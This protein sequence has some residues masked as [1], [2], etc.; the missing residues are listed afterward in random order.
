MSPGWRSPTTRS[1]PST[2]LTASMRP[3]STAKSAR[4]SPSCAAYSPGMRLMSAAT[5]ESRSRSAASSVGEDLDAA[6]LLRRHHVRAVSRAPRLSRRAC[7]DRG[8]TRRCSESAPARGRSGARGSRRMPCARR[9]SPAASRR[10]RRQEGRCTPA[11]SMPRPVHGSWCMAASPT[12]AQPGPHGTRTKLRSGPPPTTRPAGAAAA[13]RAA[14]PRWPAICSAKRAS[15]SRRSRRNASRFT[16]IATHASPA[17]LGKRYASSSPRW[18]NSAAS[19]PRDAREVAVVEGASRRR[20]VLQRGRY[21][22]R[23]ERVAAVRADDEVR[24]SAAPVAE[25]DPRHARRPHEGGDARALDELD[26]LRRTSALDQDEV[27][28]FPADRQA[29]ADA[30][31]ILGRLLPRARSRRRCR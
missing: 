11:M 28:R 17:S 4:S 19:G 3:S 13:T 25:P 27:E 9:P 24:A 12:S 26:V 14:R 6:D 5:R 23:D 22:L 31:R 10:P 7:G 18:E 15:R 20:L 29:V 8:R 1:I 30:A 2:S 21:L 16:E